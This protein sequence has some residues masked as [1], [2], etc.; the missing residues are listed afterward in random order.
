MNPV[1]AVIK[2]KSMTDSSDGSLSELPAGRKESLA[3]VDEICWIAR[4]VKSADDVVFLVLHIGYISHRLL[5][6][7]ILI[8]R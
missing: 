3:M 7:P 1:S 5:D 6:F 8:A 4:E 2:I